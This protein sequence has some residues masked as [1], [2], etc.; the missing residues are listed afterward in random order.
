MM[1]EA[2]RLPFEDPDGNTSGLGIES[3]EPTQPTDRLALDDLDDFE[4]L[5]RSPP[6]PATARHCL[7]TP[8][9]NKLGVLLRKR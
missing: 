6:R 1:A 7:T 3:D 2:L 9:G 4:N 5:T 8:V